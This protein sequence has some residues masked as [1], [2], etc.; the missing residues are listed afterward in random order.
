[1]NKFVIIVSV[2]LIGAGLSGGLQAQTFMV[3]KYSIGG[4]GGTDYL[5]AELGTGRV[6]V[7]R[8]SHVMVVDGNTGTAIGDIP[9]TPGTHGIALVAKYNHGFTT[10]RGDFTVTMFDLTTLAT[11][12]KIKIPAG[13]QDGIMYNDFSDHIILTNHSKPGTATALDPN[14]GAITGEARLEDDS[15][16]VALITDFVATLSVN[17]I[18]NSSVAGCFFPS[19]RLE[20]SACLSATEGRVVEPRGCDRMHRTD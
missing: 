9:E 11:I 1:M 2:M 10:N 5:T 20:S 17:G 16:E 6:F 4:D 19:C 15:P 7:S 14:T 18:W 12:R 8:S 13:G 3:K